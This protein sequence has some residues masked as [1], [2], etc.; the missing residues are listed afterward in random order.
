MKKIFILLICLVIMTN[1]VYA[2][3]CQYKQMES[4]QIEEDRFYLNSTLLNEGPTFESQDTGLTTAKFKVYNPYDFNITIEIPY[5]T[6]SNWYGNGIR[7]VSGIVP[8]KEFTIFDSQHNNGGPVSEPVL[9]IIEP[10]ITKKHELVTKEKEICKLCAGKN[11]SNDGISCSLPNEC[12]GNY[13][14]ESYCSNSEVCYNNNCKCA[15]NEIQC[16]DN[17]KCVL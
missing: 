8:A 12:G 9:K 11:C 14:I 10:K 13:C 4:Y 1:L 3:D 5:K 6:I 2:L 15:T 16:S 7:G 17:K